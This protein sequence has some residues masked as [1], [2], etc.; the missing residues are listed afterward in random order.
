MVS[1]G[2]AL[3]ES[4]CL[5][6]VCPASCKLCIRRP[7]EILKRVLLKNI[8]GIST[9]WTWKGW[10]RDVDVYFVHSR[11][12]WNQGCC[13]YPSFLE[14]GAVSQ[15]CATDWSAVRFT[16]PVRSS[17]IILWQWP[18]NKPLRRWWN[19]K[20]NVADTYLTWG[21]DTE[22]IIIAPTF[23]CVKL[24]PMVLSH[25]LSQIPT[26]HEP[27]PQHTCS[28]DV[29]V[30]SGVSLEQGCFTSLGATCSPEVSET[31]CETR[32]WDNL[33]R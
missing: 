17:Q 7:K 33:H 20:R 31:I 32:S 10:A 29:C 14:E 6:N 27:E 16:A 25:P 1:L 15:S 2:Q 26:G 4:I 22:F 28:A 5:V 23:P 11:W 3:S 8:T 9:K 24:L 19:Y 18:R 30:C 13:K 12:R 21:T